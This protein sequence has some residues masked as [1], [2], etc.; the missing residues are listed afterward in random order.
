MLANA[1]ARW[2]VAAKKEKRLLETKK[3]PRMSRRIIR[4]APTHLPRV[5]NASFLGAASQPSVL[6]H[7]FSVVCF[8][9]VLGVISWQNVSFHT[10]QTASL[11]VSDPLTPNDRPPHRRENTSRHDRIIEAHVKLS[12]GL[13]GRRFHASCLWPRSAMRVG[14]N[15]N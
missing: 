7:L 10:R 15:S 1:C 5:R 6:P 13:T 2:A 12:E 4:T 11:H 14:I 8:C 9:L 3:A